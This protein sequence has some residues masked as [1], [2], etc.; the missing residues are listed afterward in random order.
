MEEDCSW[1]AIFHIF[2]QGSCECNKIEF[3][4]NKLRLCICDF[5]FNEKKKKKKQQQQHKNSLRSTKCL[6]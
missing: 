5:T 3:I 2:F 6:L 4:L 1:H